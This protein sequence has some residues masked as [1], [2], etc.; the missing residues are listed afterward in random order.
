MTNTARYNTNDGQYHPHLVYKHSI[1]RCHDNLSTRYPTLKAIT[2]VESPFTL[3]STEVVAI[4]IVCAIVNA[5]AAV[6]FAIP[7]WHTADIAKF[8]L[9]HQ[10]RVA[11]TEHLTR[12]MQT[13]EERLAVAE[14]RAYIVDS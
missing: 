12:V 9:Q 7:K 8:G 1:Y 14:Q 10:S 5:S 3:T 4:V 6:P 2:M 13:D 11:L